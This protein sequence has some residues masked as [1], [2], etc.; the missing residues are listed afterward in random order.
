MDWIY[1][2]LMAIGLL[3]FGVGV[4]GRVRAKMQAKKAPQLQSTPLPPSTVVAPRPEHTEPKP[5]E[6]HA[7]DVRADAT[8]TAVEELHDKIATMNADPI[9]SPNKPDPAVVDFIR[10]QSKNK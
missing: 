5:E 1:T 2:L 10:S 3:V 9:P 8:R 7:L 4:G 6:V